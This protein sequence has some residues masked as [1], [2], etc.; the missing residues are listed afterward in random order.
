MGLRPRYRVTANN[1]DI[2]EAIKERLISLR[3]TDEA[4]YHSDVLEI[5]LDNS[6]PA[7]TLKK[8]PTGAELDVWLGYDEKLQHMGLYVVDEIE[9]A[10]WPMTMTIRARAAMYEQTKNGK[11]DMQSQKSR[12]WPSGT[13]LGEIVD[14]IAKEHNMQSSVAKALRVIALPHH[15]Q[16]EESDLSFLA[17]IANK[18]DAFVKPSGGKLVV[19]KHGASQSASGVA[20]PEV[21]VS[22]LDCT[23]FRMTEAARE[24]PGTVIAYWHTTKR[25]KKIEVVIGHGEPIKRIRHYFPTEAAAKAAAN[26]EQSKRKRGQNTLS[27]T[28][29][30]NPAFQAEGLINVSLFSDEIDGKWLIKRVE[31]D[32][33]LGGYICSVE[34]EKPNE[35]KKDSI[36]V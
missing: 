5:A 35:A 17:R 31:H 27:I 15:D 6:D 30:G 11:L 26:A 10:G 12:S 20:L 3:V 34:A 36:N 25:A 33:G 8:P 32:I 18:Y 1:V 23:S 24:A 14:K 19:A 7:K 4:G 2:T 28:L 21:L 16:S 9:Q 22:A 13:T 29:P